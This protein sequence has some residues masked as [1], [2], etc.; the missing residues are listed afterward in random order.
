MLLCAGLGTRLKPLTD[1]LPKCLMPVNGRPLLEYWLR[2]LSGPEIG[3]ILV[4]LHHH[5]DLVSQFIS[6]S[7]CASHVT[8]VYEP[9]LLGTGGTLL[10]NRRFFGSAPVLMAHGDNLTCFDVDALLRAHARRAEGTDITMMTFVTPTP[11]SCGIV[12]V[13]ARGVVTGFH[14]KVANPPGDLANAAVYVLEPSVLDFLASIGKPSIDVSTE[15]LPAYVGRIF[16]YHNSAYH[17]DIGTLESLLHAQFDYPLA[18]AR[19]R[20]ND[21]ADPWLTLLRRDDGAA[22]RGFLSALDRCLQQLSLR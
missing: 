15:V 10:A 4:N 20:T 22:E 7:P 9:S 16:T 19:Q 11:Q 6:G 13:D 8:T 2:L 5:A 12:E 14:E 21:P 1:C 18:A 3:G 17:R